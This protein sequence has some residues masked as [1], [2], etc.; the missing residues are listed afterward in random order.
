[1]TE[2]EWNGWFCYPGKHIVT[3][4]EVPMELLPLGEGATVAACPEHQTPEE[5]TS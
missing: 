1:M 3:D 4:S 5:V 2:R